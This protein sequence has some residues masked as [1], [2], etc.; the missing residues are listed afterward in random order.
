MNYT[1]F[2]F[3]YEAVRLGNWLQGVILTIWAVDGICKYGILQAHWTSRTHLLSHRQRRGRSGCFGEWWN[4][5]VPVKKNNKSFF[6]Q[7]SPTYLY[8]PL[9]LFAV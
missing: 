6:A 8:K 1:L 3:N 9:R 5:G 2:C 4:E 7:G